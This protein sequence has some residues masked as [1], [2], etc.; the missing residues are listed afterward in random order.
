MTSL[1]LYVGMWEFWDP[2]C[3]DCGQADLFTLTISLAMVLQVGHDVSLC[4]ANPKHWRDVYASSQVGTS[5]TSWLPFS[6]G[7]VCIRTPC[8]HFQ[9]SSWHTRGSFSFPQLI[10]VCLCTQR[11]LI[12]NTKL[13]SDFF[14]HNLPS[15]ETIKSGM[16]KPRKD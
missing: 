3:A 4:W 11:G 15:P 5:L 8:S 6:L 16:G 13:I 9:P 1:S 14:V 2:Q 7:F 10:I 12:W